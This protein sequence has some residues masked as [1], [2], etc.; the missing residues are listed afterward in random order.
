MT[1]RLEG[2]AYRYAG[3]DGWALSGIDLELAPGQVVGICGASE[4]GKSTLC[5]VASGLAPA[6]VGGTLNGRV[7]IDG[8]DS[9]KARPF[10]L[11]QRCAILFQQPRTQ[12][13]GTAGTTWEEVALG[14]RNLALP[15][16]EVIERT[17][18]ALAALGIEELAER[19]PDRLSG[20]QMQL[21]ALAGVLA[22]RP[23]YLLLDEPTAQLDPMGSALV[24]DAI[25]RLAESGAGILLTE[26]KAD[27]LA[28]LANRV[29]VLQGGRVVAH[30][31]AA[32]VLSDPLLE[33]AWGVTPPSRVR[34]AR[35]ID[36]AGL[37]AEL[38]A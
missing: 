32:E 18:S 24:A 35:A 25:A 9:S 6:T 22:M 5:L 28:R 30:G 29:A 1:L 26:Q 8:L 2:V 12:L 11:A 10:E 37:R 33:G 34:L 27:L 19:E 3:G 38:P 14:P 7:S 36:A 23:A 15:L 21:V 20:G 13:S 16:A 31:P 17:W 4:A